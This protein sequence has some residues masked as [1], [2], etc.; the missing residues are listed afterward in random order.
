MKH[1]LLK[2]QVPFSMCGP[3]FCSMKISQEIR[4][5]AEAEKEWQQNQKSLSKERD[6]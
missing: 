3:K 6:L 4:D 2:V 5:V 1:F